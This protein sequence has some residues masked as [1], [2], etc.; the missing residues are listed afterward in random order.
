MQF[1]KSKLNNSGNESETKQKS[2]KFK[3]VTKQNF[4]KKHVTITDSFFIT[5]YLSDDT[6]RIFHNF[7]KIIFYY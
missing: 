5:E 6:L 3:F 4:N 7:I 2:V 1:S